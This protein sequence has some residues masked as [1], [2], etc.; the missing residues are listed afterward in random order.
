MK[1]DSSCNACALCL[2][3]GLARAQTERLAQTFSRQQARSRVTPVYHASL[4]IEAV[5]K[6]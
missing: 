6:S 1:S 3:R 4:V 5:A 2:V